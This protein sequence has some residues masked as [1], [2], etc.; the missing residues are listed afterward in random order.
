MV[1]RKV[2]EQV[3]VVSA[4]T[5]DGLKKFLQ[6]IEANSGLNRVTANGNACWLQ[7]DG[8][9][10]Q[11]WY[12]NTYG[13][14]TPTFT[15]AG[16]S[17]VCLTLHGDPANTFMLFRYCDGTGKNAGDPITWS[18]MLRVTPTSI[19]WMGNNLWT[20]ASFN[21]SNY[22]AKAELDV[23]DY[24]AKTELVIA[25]EI[26]QSAIGAING[27]K[28]TGSAAGSLAG[29]PISFH[30]ERTGVGVVGDQ[31][32][33]GNGSSGGQ[34]AVMP[35]AGK[36]IAATLSASA[37]NGTVTLRPAI[38]SVE[39]AAAYELSCT[40]TGASAFDILDVQAT[41][42]AF[43]VGDALNWRTLAIPTAVNSYNV[44]F[45]VKFD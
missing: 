4:Q 44:T 12:W 36:L 21:P 10:R 24:W 26:I 18:D 14:L 23:S 22:W 2:S 8:T 1:T 37:L 17:A 3:D 38:N 13:G 42:L 15:T 43:N 25:S 45:F 32:S 39:Q 30:C 29:V 11:H 31:L 27:W 20:A 5:I 35:C 9:G 28:G 40:S 34:G 41:P 33:F 19:Q 6:I 16:E 7:Q